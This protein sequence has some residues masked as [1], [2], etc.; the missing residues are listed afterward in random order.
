[1]SAGL[2]RIHTDTF[3]WKDSFIV[4]SL[5]AFILIILGE[6][7]A[8]PVPGLAY[9]LI[10]DQDV[11]AAAELYYYYIGI[12]I[13]LI[14]FCFFVKKYRF[15]LDSYAKGLSGNNRKGFLGGILTG[16]VLCGA[17]ILGASINKDIVLFYDGFRPLTLIFIFVGVLIQSGAEEA[18][19]R[20]FIYQNLRK[21]YR[22]PLVAILLN[23]LLFAA[24][25]LFNT[26]ITVLSFIV[27]MLSGILFSLMVYYFDSFWA[28]VAT[29]TMWNY[30][31]NIIFGLPNSGH[32][33][34]FSI[35]RLD[36]AKA[37]NSFFYNVDFGIE[38]TAMACL[39]ICIAIAAEIIIGSRKKRLSTEF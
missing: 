6:L 12:W 33:S 7:I 34:T 15:V 22:S 1:M 3:T 2:R 19:Y 20:G 35:F 37:T 30:T 9:A 8:I 17:C 5:L 18:L 25:H 28:A 14:F 21:G 36:A 38:G 13:A 10:K 26:G 32:V 31:Q 27:I 16:F 39:A 29:H 24:G 4:V 11:A 23:S